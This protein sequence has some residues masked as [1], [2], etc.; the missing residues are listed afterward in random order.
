MSDSRRDRQNRK[1]RFGES[2]REDGRY[3]YTY[4]DAFGKRRDIYSWRLDAG[5]PYPPNKRHD[6]SLREKEMQVAKDTYDQ[7]AVNG[8][9]YTVLQLVERY[10]SLKTGVRQSTLTGYQTVV[11]LLKK[12]PFGEM[13]IDKIKLSDAKLWLIKLQREDGK[14]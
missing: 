6:L 1:L 13:R 7:I 10:I 14:G 9:G 2:Q 11:N 4:L 12:D 5:D 3:R 8:G